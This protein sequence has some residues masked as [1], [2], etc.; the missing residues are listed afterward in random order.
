M[1]IAPALFLI[2][3]SAAVS[4]ML[5]RSSSERVERA[6]R[7]Y[8]FASYLEEQIRLARTPIG[9]AA[10]AFDGG[11]TILDSLEKDEYTSRLVE[12][13]SLG[14]PE[15]ACANA[16]L[17]KN[18]TEKEMVRIKDEETRLRKAKALLPSLL[19]LLILILFL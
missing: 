5:L 8:E 12:A 1:N 2:A 11:K 10:D 13:I 9:D 3:S 17:L 16:A 18:H 4:V 6:R 15:T 19:A 7:S 14:T